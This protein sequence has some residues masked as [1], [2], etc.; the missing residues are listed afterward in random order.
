MWHKSKVIRKRLN[1]RQACGYEI[2]EKSDDDDVEVG[3]LW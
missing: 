1:E 3:E 2:I